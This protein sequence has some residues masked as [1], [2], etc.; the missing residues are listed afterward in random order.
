MIITEHKDMKTRSF[1]YT[2]RSPLY[3]CVFVFHNIVCPKIFFDYH[4][5]MRKLNYFLLLD[6]ILPYCCLF[7]SVISCL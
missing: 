5:N 3:L 7:F 6:K 1:Y 2:V 4:L